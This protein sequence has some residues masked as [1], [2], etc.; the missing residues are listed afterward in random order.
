MPRKRRLRRYGAGA[1]R[2]PLVEPKLLTSVDQRPSGIGRSRPPA[3]D[4]IQ[5]RRAPL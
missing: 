2:V 4:S 3:R 1:S 5:N